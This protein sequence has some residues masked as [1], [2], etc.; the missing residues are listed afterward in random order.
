MLKPLS[1]T[2]YRLNSC[3]INRSNTFDSTSAKEA[4]KRVAFSEEGTSHEEH[5]DKAMAKARQQSK[6][7]RNR[8]EKT[9]PQPKEPDISVIGSSCTW[10]DSELER[11]NVEL[12]RD[13]D[14]RK[15]IPEKF[16]NFDH[17]KNYKNCPPLLY[18][19]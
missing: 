15:M 14:V 1:S 17:L 7:K 13:I 8:R 6:R 11:F 2:N 12:V 18:A 9:T 10:K 19:Y 4:G 5:V 3:L 16:F